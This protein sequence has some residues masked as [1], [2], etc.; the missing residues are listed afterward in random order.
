[1]AVL[2]HMYIKQAHAHLVINEL[3]MSHIPKFS[4]SLN[5]HTSPYSCSK[6]N[7]GQTTPNPT[8]TQYL[9][10]LTARESMEKSGLQH[11]AQQSS[12]RDTSNTAH[13]VFTAEVE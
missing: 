7:I 13:N 12:R 1:M 8:Q 3:I 9:Y 10:T 2:P 11:I 5:K 6:N 4:I